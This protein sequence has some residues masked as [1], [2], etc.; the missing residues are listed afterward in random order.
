MIYLVFHFMQVG[1]SVFASNIG[2]HHFVGLAGTGAASGYAIV[3]FE[4]LVR[5]NI[6]Y[7]FT[8]FCFQKLYF[9]YMSISVFLLFFKSCDTL[10]FVSFVTKC[11]SNGAVAC[12]KLSFGTHASLL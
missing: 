1:A 11:Y 7:S 8:V 3:L 12:E 2:S 5:I 6:V 9:V 10:C 4:W